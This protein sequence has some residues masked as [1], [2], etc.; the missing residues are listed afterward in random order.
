MQAQVATLP[1]PQRVGLLQAEDGQA[2]AGRDQHRAAA[3]ER[4]APAVG[5]V[6]ARRSGPA[7]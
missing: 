4:L 1:Q 5:E 7:R 6:P 3:V 2:H